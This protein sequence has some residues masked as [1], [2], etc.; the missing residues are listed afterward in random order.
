VTDIVYASANQFPQVA[1]KN[2]GNG[3]AINIRIQDAEAQ[4]PKHTNIYRFPEIVATLSCGGAPILVTCVPEKYVE[5]KKI[6]LGLTPT[7]L[8]PRGATTASTLVR[9]E[10]ANIEGQLYFVEERIARQSFE[11]VRFGRVASAVSRPQYP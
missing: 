11:I 6:S 10:F 2:I 3:T 4:H 9:L 7:D 5:G 1:V 8:D